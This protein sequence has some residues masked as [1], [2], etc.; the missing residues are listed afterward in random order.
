MVFTIVLLACKLHD[1]I[2]AFTSNFK[3]LLKKKLISFYCYQYIH[4][5]PV[6]RGYKL[7]CH[8]LSMQ[9]C[10]PK[11]LPATVATNYP[12]PNTEY[13]DWIVHDQLLLSWLLSSMSDTTLAKFVGLPTSHKVWSKLETVFANQSMANALN[14]WQQLQRTVKGSISIDEYLTN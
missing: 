9:P 14:Y 6:I 1:L 2:V 4:L 12:L 10:P 13:E 3:I 7:D 11:F 5:F 8:L